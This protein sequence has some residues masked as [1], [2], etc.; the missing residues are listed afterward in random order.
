MGSGAHR[1][2][3]GREAADLDATCREA[4]SS[5]ADVDAK[6]L[7][8]DVTPYDPLVWCER[9]LEQ[10]T[11]LKSAYRAYPFR[12]LL[13]SLN[14]TMKPSPQVM[15]CDQA[16]STLI[17]VVPRMDRPCLLSIGSYPTR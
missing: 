3:Y 2:G 17:A 15:T 8:I 9:R 13:V 16:L 1:V 5:A 10:D 7:T 4:P 6:G 12:S 14:A 11:Y